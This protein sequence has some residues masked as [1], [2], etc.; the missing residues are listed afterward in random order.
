MLLSKAP[1]ARRLSQR[2]FSSQGRWPVPFSGR[3]DPRAIENIRFQT[4]FGTS[5]VKDSNRFYVICTIIG[6]ASITYYVAHRDKAPITHRSRMIDMPRRTE[7]ALGEQAFQDL[8]RMHD[9]RVVSTEG[10]GGSG[11]WTAAITRLEHA[12]AVRV[13]RVGERV[14]AAAAQAHPKL[15]DDFKWEFVLIRA[16]SEANA[17]CCPGGKVAVF[18]GLLQVTPDDDSLAA[19]LAHEIGHAVARHSAERI[20]FTKVIV[21]LQVLVNMVIDFAG[22]T[23][24]IA[25]LLLHL[26]YSR[27]LELEADH[28]GLELMARACYDPRASPKMF[29]KLADLQEQPDRGGSKSKMAVSLLSTHPVFSDRI[30]KIN[31]L[32]PEAERIYNSSCPKVQLRDWMRKNDSFPYGSSFR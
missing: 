22:F 16:P 12:E 3:K 32:L 10:S 20:S 11:L 8:L 29:S 24:L 2:L 5:S 27:K 14:A 1:Y 18:S 30:K 15:V 13:R 21:V 23:N 31:K 17:V 19:V 7:L 4:R 26:P 6:G 9:G 25:H 28:I